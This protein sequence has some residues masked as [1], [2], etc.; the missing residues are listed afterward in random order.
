M[1]LMLAFMAFAAWNQ[2]YW[3]ITLEEDHFGWL[4]PAFALF[5]LYDRRAK[6]LAAW[7]E[8]GTAGSVRASG[9]F[10]ILLNVL[11]GGTF[12]FGL[13]ALIAGAVDRA[14]G[15]HSFKGTFIASFGI[16]LLLV[17]VPWL[18]A[19]T[20]QRPAAGTVRT[21]PRV[22]LCS[23]LLFPAIVWLFSEPLLTQVE[24]QLSS[25]ILGPMAAI[26]A[27]IFDFLG[28]P[29]TREGNIL[30]MPDH[31][32]VGI[33]EACSGIRSF[34]ACL[35]AGTFLGALMLK[36]FWQQ[37]LLILLATFI[38]LILNFAR[39]LFLTTWAYNHGTASIEGFVHDS[40]GYIVMGLTVCALFLILSCLNRNAQSL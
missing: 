4:T 35:Y 19:P 6:L 25:F 13:L 26:V 15:G 33:E 23:L 5:V 14:G 18:A 3:W 27:R 1:A 30:L 29:I 28:S 7:N 20:A 37:A 31:G 24:T 34:A 11:A 36:R 22:A 16:S 12:I 40:A 10:G 17:A 38:A 39:S 8:C 2:S 9:L 21:D 32:R